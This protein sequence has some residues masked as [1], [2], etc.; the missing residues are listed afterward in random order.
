M[1]KLIGQGITNF[2][3]QRDNRPL[4]PPNLRTNNSK[5]DYK[6]KKLKIFSMFVFK[7]H[8]PFSTINFQFSII[9]YQY[10]IFNFQ[11]SI[12]II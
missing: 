11:L 1:R 12:I 4:L 6:I 9:N 2:A 3:E 7:F 8:F 5:R 10:L